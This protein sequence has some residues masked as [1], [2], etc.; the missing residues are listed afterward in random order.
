[1]KRP[2]VYIILLLLLGAC[3]GREMK[4][5]LQMVDSLNQAGV[6][7]DTI[8]F[9]QDVVDYFDRWGTS[10]NR[11]TAHYLL[12][13]VFRDQNNTPMA[14]RCFRDAASYADSTAADCNFRQLSRVY[15]QMADLFHRQRSPHLELEAERQAV[16]CAWKAKDTL[17][18]VMF[19]SYLCGPYYMLNEM[20]S[21]L[22]VI[23]E[24][25][26]WYRRMGRYDLAAGF[27]PMAVDVY[28]QRNDY[29]EAKRAM[30]QYERFSGFFDSKGNIQ[31][32]KLIYFKHK[33]I[34]YEQTNQ[35]DSAEYYYRRLL[36]HNP[37]YNRKGTAY[38]GLLS[39]YSR[40]NK[41]DSIS[42]YSFLYCQANDSASFAHSADAITQAQALYNY[43]E[44]ERLAEKKERE[45]KYYK[46]AIIISALILFLSAIIVYRYW[47]SQQ[48]RKKAELM[49]ANAEYASLLSQYEQLQHDMDLSQHDMSLYRQEKELEHQELLQKLA[50]Y[51]D[52]PD[53]VKH[54]DVEQA[55]LHSPIVSELHHLASQAK[56]PSSVQWKE[57]RSFTEKELPNFFSKVNI[58]EAG[59]SPQEVLTSVLIRLQFS[60]GELSAL[61]G[62]SKQR[63]NNI[64]RA[65]NQKLFSEEGAT[66][67]NYNITEL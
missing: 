32:D 50:I 7:L 5:K 10:D 65:I 27:L 46:N 55:M 33:G 15:G 42:K 53:I 41:P 39:L 9:M 44:Q 17:A 19:Y 43:E 58:R 22:Y 30:D 48:Q 63:I 25:E 28:L 54:W 52:V 2:F 6:S 57:L 59:L 66:T 1:M 61:F 31:P 26:E 47:R 18:A 64:K 21:V 29:K 4:E 16:N 56:Q 45:A 20:D 35:L 49:A 3:T 36:T 37:D 62:V 12:G 13:C 24:S 11:M 60:Q 14:L 38:K 40:L 67:L 23:R 8:A 34:Y 51:Q